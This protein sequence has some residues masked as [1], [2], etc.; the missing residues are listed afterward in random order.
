MPADP[1]I[2][3]ALAEAADALNALLNNEQT[4]ERL[5][6]AA[7]LL[8]RTFRQGGKVLACGNGGSMCDAMH[9]CEEL[10][11]RFRGD[12][13]ALPALAMSDASHLTCA[14]NDYGFEQVFA[15]YTQ[16]HCQTVDCLL[17]IST[18]GT[19]KNILAAAEA[20][21]ERGASIIALTGKPDSPLGALATIDLC[22]PGGRFSDRVQELHIK[23]I[24]ILI[25]QVERRMFG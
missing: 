14:G 17:A 10:T 15:R 23:C 2:Q 20:A 16:A 24:H 25:E 11:G 21:R 3:A 22:T 4:H 7:D 19:S 6:A 9:F 1:T 12:R 5:D 13:P 8:V 18:S